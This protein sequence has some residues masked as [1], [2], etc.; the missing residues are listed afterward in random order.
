MWKHNNIPQWQNWIGFVNGLAHMTSFILANDLIP[1]L[2]QMRSFPNAQELCNAGGSALQAAV[3]K[4]YGYGKFGLGAH[5][6]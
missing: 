2:R 5:V 1:E 6:L 3:H 4:K